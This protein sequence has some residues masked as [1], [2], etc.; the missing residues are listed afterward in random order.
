LLP[1]GEGQIKTPF[2]LLLTVK[3]ER[4]HVYNKYTGSFRGTTFIY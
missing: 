4:R 1:S 3:D 2:I